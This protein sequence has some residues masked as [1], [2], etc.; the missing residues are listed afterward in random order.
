MGMFGPDGVELITKERREQQKKW[1]EDHDDG[2]DSGELA[3]A[4]A[5]LVMMETDM[6]CEVTNDI[7][8]LCAK[9]QGERLRQLVIAGALIGAE[10]DRLHRLGVTK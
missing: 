6:Y 2:H 3:M 4:A 9:H 10:I 5:E 1:S 8:G 7:F